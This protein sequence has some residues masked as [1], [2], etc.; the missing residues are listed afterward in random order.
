[1]FSEKYHTTLGV[2]ID[3]K[4]LLVDDQSIELLL[5]DLAGEDEFIKVRGSYL[6][7]SAG[8][9][10][11]ADGSRAATLDVVMDLKEKLY[12]EVGSVPFIVVVNKSDIK[13]NW[14]IDQAQLDAV[15]GAAWPVIETSAKN[16][17]NVEYAFQVLAQALIAGGGI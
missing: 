2:K 12:Q 15:Q 7:G 3:K 6:R 8:A 9:I 1:M 14:Q 11:V 17:D 4:S 13:E 10:L 16:N 5:W